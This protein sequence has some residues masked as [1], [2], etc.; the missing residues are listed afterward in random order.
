[1][2]S[3]FYHIGG[4]V[5]WQNKVIGAAFVAGAFLGAMFG[6]EFATLHDTIKNV[7]SKPLMLKSIYISLKSNLD[8]LAPAVEEIRRSNIKLNCP[9]EEIKKSI[10]DMKKAEELIC[11]FKSQRWNY[12]LQPNQ[13]RKLAEFSEAI[14]KFFQ[15]HMQ[16]Q[17]RW[18]TLQILEELKSLE[19]KLPVKKSGKPYMVQS[20]PDFTVGLDLPLK[21]LKKQLLKEKEQH[22]LL[23][24]P[25]GCG[26][27]T[28]AKMLC[29]DE[30]IKGILISLSFC[31][32]SIYNLVSALSLCGKLNLLFMEI[33]TNSRH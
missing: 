25:G 14:M 26:K 11:E 33:K 28:L 6:K 10:E 12:L 7:G 1:M 4:L 27:T 22:V 23:T 5:N 2:V 29:Q 15:V 19:E 32:T 8:L 20:P 13:A 18:D 9:E 17:V 16:A 3:F 30:E 31:V 24:A 21:V